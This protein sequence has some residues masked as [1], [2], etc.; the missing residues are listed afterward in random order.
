MYIYVQHR[1]LALTQYISYVYKLADVNKI[2]FTLQDII[3]EN[4]VNLGECSMERPSVTNL[5]YHLISPAISRCRGLGCDDINIALSG[6]EGRR[7]TPTP[8]I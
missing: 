1:T 6:D 8:S 7:T 4:I 3:T 5:Q 2:N